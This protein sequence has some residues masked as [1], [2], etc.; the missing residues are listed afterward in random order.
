MHVLKLG[1]DC[2]VKQICVLFFFL[3]KIVRLH[4]VN[5]L[6]DLKAHLSKQILPYKYMSR[7]VCMHK[8]NKFN[9]HYPRYFLMGQSLKSLIFIKNSSAYVVCM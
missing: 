9:V 6:I 5:T 1:D 3:N 2:K 4:L 8:V 7:Y